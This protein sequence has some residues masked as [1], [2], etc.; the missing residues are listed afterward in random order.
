[1]VA[2]RSPK[3][4]AWVRL[5][6]LAPFFKEIFM[7]KILTIGVTS[8]FL[9][10]CNATVYDGGVYRPRPTIDIYATPAPVYMPPTVHNPRYEDHR[11]PVIVDRRVRC[12]TTWDR[13][14][15][16]Y[17]ERKVCG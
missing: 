16:G 17:V 9:A 6:P 3:P 11:R 7:Y 14:P 10:G 5:L 4:R 12:Y 2:H 13:T 8:L 15:R 1:M